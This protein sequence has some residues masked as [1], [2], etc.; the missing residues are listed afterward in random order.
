MRLESPSDAIPSKV[1]FWVVPANVTGQWAVT[2]RTG[3]KAQPYALRLGQKFQFAEGSI[4]AGG[5]R[6]AL[7]DVKLAGPRLSFTARL[8]D[9]SG[10]P[11]VHEF[12]ARVSGDSMEGTLKQ[13]GSSRAMTWRAQRTGGKVA[14]GPEIDPKLDELKATS[15]VQ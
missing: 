9:A 3:A 10:K 2:A 12:S 8:P 13:E 4:E 7:A 6:A 15:G 1:Y 11:L 5:A 14:I